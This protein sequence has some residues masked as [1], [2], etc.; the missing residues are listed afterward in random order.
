M[1]QGSPTQLVI[2]CLDG[3]LHVIISRN[4]RNWFYHVTWVTVDE[5]L[6]HT[7]GSIKSLVLFV[8][9]RLFTC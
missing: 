7:D 1:L 2:C 9:F 3:L 5:Q 4:C 8:N 6:L